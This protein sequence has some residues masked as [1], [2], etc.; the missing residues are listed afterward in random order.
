[1][2]YLL[3]FL[4][5]LEVWVCGGGTA[6]IF[7]LTTFT[8]VNQHIAQGANLIFFIPTSIVSIFLN[9]KNK[10]IEYK[11]AVVVIIS[12]IIGAMI[13]TMFSGNMPVNILK[14]FFGFFLLFIAFFEIYS[15]I[16]SYR[17]VKNKDVK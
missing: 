9:I 6:L 11:T 7:F 14:K 2:F 17:K 1:M 5:L 4:E 8:S 16:K 15:L 12:G 3:L 10:N 13:G